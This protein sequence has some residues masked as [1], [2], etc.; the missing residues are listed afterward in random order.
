VPTLQVIDTNILVYA[1]DRRDATKQRRARR[2]LAELARAGTA[3]LPAQALTEFSS[4]MLRR[5][6][7][8]AQ[9]RELTREIEWL[10]RA[11]DILPLT[12]Q[13]V[14]EALRGVRDHGLSFYDAQ[15]WGAAHLAQAPVLLSEDFPSGETRDGVSFV[16]PFE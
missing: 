7:P 2:L 4:V 13:V 5:P 3:A 14:L 12:T 10:A 6:R 16:N 15:I 9:P 8:P 11:F 1:H